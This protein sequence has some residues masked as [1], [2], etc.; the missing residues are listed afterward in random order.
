MHWSRGLLQ[1]KVGKYK[2][3]WHNQE[4]RVGTN[5]IL[6]SFLATLS[7]LPFELVAKTTLIVAALLFILDPYQG[8]RIVSLIAVGVVLLINRVRQ[9]FVTS[10][11]NESDQNQ[12]QNEDTKKAQ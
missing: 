6:S 10:N 4:S 7:Y 1:V 3:S 12:Q 11:G 8:S 5:L 9:Q 2:L